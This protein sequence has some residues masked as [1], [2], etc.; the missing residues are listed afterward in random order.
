MNAIYKTTTKYTFEEYKKYSWSL[1]KTPANFILYGVL[2]ILLILLGIGFSNILILAFAIVY[3]F[4]IIWSRNRRIKKV[5]DSNKSTMNL[6]VTFEFFD[7]YF[8]L[9]D[10]T[11][12]NKLSYNKLFKIRETKD[13]FYLMISKNQGLILIKKN[14]PEGL[15]EFLKNIDLLAKTKKKGE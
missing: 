11:G 10:E 2:E 1:F 12:D 8:A 15:S 4:V 5:F 6:T 14:M 9:H 13:N 3:P 7:K